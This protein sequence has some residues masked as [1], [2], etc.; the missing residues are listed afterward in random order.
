MSYQT[1][2]IFPDQKTYLW[3][4]VIRSLAAKRY[5][6]GTRW[7][8]K[9]LEKPKERRATHLSASARAARVEDKRKHGEI[10]QAR[11]L[12]PVDQE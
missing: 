6:K 5:I 7:I 9:A 8:Q 2:R 10:K 4:S 1:I 3:Q 11:R 12:K